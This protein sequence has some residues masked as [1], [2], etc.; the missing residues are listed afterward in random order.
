MLPNVNR[1]SIPL[2]EG[3]EEERGGGRV[4]GEGGGDYS[5]TVRIK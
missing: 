1:T 5:V 3:G 4:G 2:T